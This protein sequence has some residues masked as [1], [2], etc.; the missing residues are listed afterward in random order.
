LLQRQIH[1]LEGSATDMSKQIKELLRVNTELR[2]RKAV[3]AGSDGGG[4]TSGADAEGVIDLH[5]VTV[6]G[7]EDMQTQNVALR[8]SLRELSEQREAEELARVSQI[9][10]EMQSK[11]DESLA[12]VSKLREQQRNQQDA[13]KVIVQQRDSWKMMAENASPAKGSLRGTSDVIMTQ[14]GRSSG[15]RS[16]IGSATMQASDAQI[17]ADLRES[18]EKYKADRVGTDRL[19]A[20]DQDRLRS[21]LDAKRMEY[22]QLATRLEST[23]QRHGDLQ[24]TV[25]GLMKERG[26][27]S[28]RNSEYSGV[29]SKHE[30]KLRDLTA[31]LDDARGELR[32]TKAMVES[33]KNEKETLSATVARLEQENASGVTERKNQTQLFS[34]LQ[35]IIDGMKAEQG[36]RV[37]S[38]SREVEDARS[39]VSRPSA[40]TF[41][42]V[43]CFA[44]FEDAA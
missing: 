39:E 11:L 42:R 20:E 25:D 36:E 12:Q 21:E 30:N 38:L 4:P 35:S 33:T 26:M 27:L 9:E 7:I 24:L 10:A 13:V 14:G 18:F 17:L 43:I 29:V 6:A 32:R 37:K 31:E 28:H 44:P 5:L 41:D 34:S 15:S 3:S 19:A 23:V 1:S 2:T 22:V 40:P 16:S 8:A